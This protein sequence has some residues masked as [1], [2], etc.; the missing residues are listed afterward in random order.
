MKLVVRILRGVIISRKQNVNPRA[1]KA[2]AS[3][4]GS[5]ETISEISKDKE[6]VQ[7]LHKIFY[8]EVKDGAH[9]GGGG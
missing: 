1:P 5:S 2:K 8:K 3:G 6:I 9:I 4:V 7:K